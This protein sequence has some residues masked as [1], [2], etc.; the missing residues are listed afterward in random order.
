MLLHTFGL[1][2]QV[3]IPG[4][5]SGKCTLYP[6][7]DKKYFSLRIINNRHVKKKNYFYHK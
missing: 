2:N 1:R 5:K 6:N 4:T 3:K 7:Y